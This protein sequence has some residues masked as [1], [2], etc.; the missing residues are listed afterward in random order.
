[1]VLGHCGV[2]SPGA[3]PATYGRAG[4][5]GGGR[6]APQCEH[7]RPAAGQGGEYLAGFAEHVLRL[8]LAQLAAQVVG[9]VDPQPVEAGPGRGLRGTFVNVLH[10]QPGCA[11]LFCPDRFGIAA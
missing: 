7:D 9:V 8:A 10:D 4:C 3:G 11:G 5:R 1:M 6:G 2:L